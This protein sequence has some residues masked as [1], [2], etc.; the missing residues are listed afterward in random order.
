MSRGR[1]V[2]ILPARTLNDDQGS[3]QK[4]RKRSHARASQKDDQPQD[5]SIGSPN[6]G[7]LDD[8]KSSS[9]ERANADDGSNRP[10]SQ[11]AA[12]EPGSDERDGDWRHSQF[13]MHDLSFILHPCHESSTP[14]KDQEQ[15]HP[16]NDEMNERRHTLLQRASQTLELSQ[17]TLDFL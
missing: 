16:R 14:D 12:Q 8:L 15:E 1:R 4:S 3:I 6:D 11:G 17:S 2:F 7:W 9:T 10:P 13:N 5:S